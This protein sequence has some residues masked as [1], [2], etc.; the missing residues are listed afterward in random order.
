VVRLLAADVAAA[1]PCSDPVSAL[2][3]LLVR[4]RRVDALRASAT[5]AR[6]PQLLARYAWLLED[7][8]RVAEAEALLREFAAGQDRPQYHAALVGLLGRQGRYEEAVEA[9][10][11]TFGHFDG[12]DLLPVLTDML[13]E[14]GRAGR[15]VELVEQYRAE[16]IEGDR[17]GDAEEDHADYVAE[18]LWWI[19]PL[20]WRL[21]GAAGRHREAIDEIGAQPAEERNRH[22]DLLGRLLEGHGRADEAAEL[23]RSTGTVEAVEALAG[24]L[25]RQGRAAEAVAAA[26]ALAVRRAARG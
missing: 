22:P 2:E 19:R 4:H 14:A 17:S 1:H 16:H 15:A 9:G 21:L 12:N 18:Q 10:R 23:L 25:L 20:R 7:L 6:A 11:P 8:G 13:V 26:P 24:L 5:G 3:D